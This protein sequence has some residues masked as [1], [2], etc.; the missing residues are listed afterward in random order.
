SS[1]SA[2]PGQVAAGIAIFESTAGFRSVRDRKACRGDAVAFGPVEFCLTTLSAGLHCPGA[3][4]VKV[5]HR[6]LAE[7]DCIAIG[8]LAWRARD[9][10]KS[11]CRQDYA[12]L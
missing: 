5:V 1:P 11:I 6:R 10:A 12:R 8:S 2:L 9:S 4:H 7:V 3:S